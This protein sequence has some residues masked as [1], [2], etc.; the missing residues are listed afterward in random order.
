MGDPLDPNPG[1]EIEDVTEDMSEQ[2]QE[3][4][5]EQ[6]ASEFGNGSEE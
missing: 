2:E 3:E 4:V 1:M 5:R 6:L